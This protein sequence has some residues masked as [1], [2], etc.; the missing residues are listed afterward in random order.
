VAD[1]LGPGDRFTMPT[2]ERADKIMGDLMG[3]LMG[4]KND[5]GALFGGLFGG[6]RARAGGEQK[7]PGSSG[8]TTRWR[9]PRPDWRPQA[10][11]RAL[12]ADVQAVLDEY[13]DHLPLTGRQIFYR[14]VTAGYPKTM[15][16]YTALLE[17]LVN[18][19][20]AGTIPSTPSGTTGSPRSGRTVSTARR[21]F[22][23]T[24][25]PGPRTTAGIASRARTQSWRSGARRRA[26]FPSS[27]GSLIRSGLPCSHRRGSIRS[28]RSTTPPGGPPSPGRSS[29][30]TSATLTPLASTCSVQHSRTW[31]PGPTAWGP[32]VEFVRVA[33]TPEQVTTYG[34]ATAPPK[35]S[36]KR[37]FSGETCQAEALDPGD[38]ATIVREA[39][40]DHTDPDVRQD[41]L[42]VEEA[43]RTELV[44]QVARWIS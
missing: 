26:W 35:A 20:R 42:A 17:M 21:T 29:S 24:W 38:L 6:S 40:E 44:D 9:G 13:A 10:K 33:V 4:D 37:S 5:A 2:G 39:I 32:E 11:T 41:V 3:D 15:V 43:E 23:R 31:P 34:L 1:D 22:G 30:C 7:A 14:L 19:R 8:T 36:D 12:L 16:A 28:R 27:S 25:S 18:A